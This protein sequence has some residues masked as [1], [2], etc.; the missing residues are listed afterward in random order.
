MLELARA[1]GY[2]LK[3]GVAAGTDLAFTLENAPGAP[4][5][6][7]IAIGVKV[8]SIPAQGQKPQTF[9][10]TEEIVAQIEWNSLIPQQ[11]QLQDLAAGAQQL[12][13]KGINTGL[14]PG[15]PVL[16]VGDERD[17]DPG[18]ENWDFRFV[19]TIT[20][21]T[22]NDVTLVTWVK[23]LGERPVVPAE[24]PRVY[25]FRLR[26]ALFGYSA[27]EWTNLHEDIKA[28]YLNNG[29]PGQWPNFNILNNQIDLDFELSE[30]HPGKLGHVGPSKLHRAV[31]S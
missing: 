10:T 1:I 20:T 14:Q 26:A 19:E 6:A 9:E 25:A 2:E 23:G 5:K 29:D 11:T 8:L 15:D 24:N 22:K 13:L 21:D 12:Y 18:N 31:Q 30:S 7:T 3:P 4:G 27:A 17:R 16:L 28:L